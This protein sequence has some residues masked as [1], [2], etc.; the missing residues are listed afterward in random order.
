MS[1][2]FMGKALGE[3]LLDK[4][5]STHANSVKNPDKLSKFFTI[6]NFDGEG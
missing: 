4:K 3:A 2:R 5:Y 6:L 1:D